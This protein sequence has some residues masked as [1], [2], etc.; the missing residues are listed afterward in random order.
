MINEH[1]LEGAIRTAGYTQNKLAAEMKIT[2][3]TFSTKKK[4]GT[5]TLK[6]V[7]QIC[8]I[9]EIKKPEEKVDIFLG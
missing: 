9:L 7:E 4:R 6:Q 5:F 2:P 8:S 3:N 1:R